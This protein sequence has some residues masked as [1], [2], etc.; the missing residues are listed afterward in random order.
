M[1]YNKDGNQ[2]KIM[3]EINEKII[4]RIHTTRRK[5]VML[6]GPSVRK[7]MDGNDTAIRQSSSAHTV[8]TILL[9]H[10][11]WLQLGHLTGFE[12]SC[13][14]QE[15]LAWMMVGVAAVV[16]TVLGPATAR[17]TPHQWVI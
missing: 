8:L 15:G 14:R 16:W 5:R 13:R 1:L 9:C 17:T 4:T 2:S 3:I 7:E 12:G 6:H 10:C 11:C